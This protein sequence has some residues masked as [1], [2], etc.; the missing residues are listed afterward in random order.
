[1]KS[2][3]GYATVERHSPERSCSVEVRSVNNRYLEVY[4][5]LPAY[6]SSLEPDIKARV[7]A[8][9]ARGKVEV[10]V[11]LQEHRQ[12]LRVRVDPRAVE[13]ARAALEE[14]REC[15]GISS[16][17]SYADIL[18]F[19]G[20][21]ETERSFDQDEASREVMAV[22][23]EALAQWNETRCTEGRATADDMARHLERVSR[24]AE[25]FGNHAGE[26]EQ[27]IFQTV[28]D[29]FRDV[30]GDEA[31]EQRIYAET[32]ALILR[33]STSEEVSRLQSHIRTFGDLLNGQGP[34]G[35]R[36][37]FICQE[38]NREI[39]TTG[40]KTILSAVQAAVVE[41]K[42]AVEALREQVRNVE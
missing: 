20:V 9:A 19:E 25:I 6:L 10:A 3:T 24:C 22:L 30:L 23:E 2:M 39:N 17:P 35:K 13:A 42:D 7:S 36:L 16:E 29:K 32:A 1:M 34:R 40:S 5:S 37:D 26:V 33:H 15:G 41:A 4:T 12:N 11:R 28:R 38:M 27:I 31:E 18:A 21:V 8:V 14:I